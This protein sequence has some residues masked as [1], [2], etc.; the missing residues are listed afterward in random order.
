MTVLSFSTVA[1]SMTSPAQVEIWDWKQGKCV[2]VLPALGGSY[3]CGHAL[4]PDGRFVMGDTAGN[5][6]AG[7]VESWSPVTVVTTDT[8]TGL[9][10]GHDGSFVTTDQNG[11][12]KLWRNGVCEVERTGTCASWS[13]A[14]PLAVI[15][16]RLV[17]FGN[18]NYL[19]VTK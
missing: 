6:R 12:L 15:G 19:L 5:I 14:V 4:L 7:W 17:A 16:R 3:V 9:L 10:V 8:I 1:L 13:A 2:R 11:K 18:S